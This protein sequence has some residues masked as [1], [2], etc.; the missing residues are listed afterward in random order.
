MTCECRHS[1]QAGCFSMAFSLHI[2]CIMSVPVSSCRIA[3]IITSH[4]LYHV[5][6]CIITLHRLYHVTTLLS[7]H[8]PVLR[9]ACIMS[10]RLYYVKTHAHEVYHV[11]SKC[12]MSH[13]LY[14]VKTHVPSPVSCFSMA[15]SRHIA[16]IMLKLMLMR[17]AN[18]QGR[19]FTDHTFHPKI[20]PPTM[21]GAGS[22]N[23]LKAFF[24]GSAPNP[25]RGVY[26][27]GL[28]RLLS[29][30]CL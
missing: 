18:N 1:G 5:C 28:A 10:H 7:C 24:T 12:I 26:V 25:W 20:Q 19:P 30:A 9:I 23:K 14:H 22:P 15:F 11:T 21:W 8:T 4:R 29:D 13:C 27:T 16:C 2:A 6:A 17:L 3:C